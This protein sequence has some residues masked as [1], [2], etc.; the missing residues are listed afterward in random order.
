VS[1]LSSLKEHF[2]V[3]IDDQ[4]AGSFSEGQYI[5]VPV[6]PGPHTFSYARASQVSFNEKKHTLDVAPGQSVYFEVAE[7]QQGMVTVM[8]PHQVPPEQGQPAL[9]GLQA[10]GRD[11]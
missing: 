5:S 3:A 4:S 2:G 11:D 8:Y 1:F 10:P 6:Q 9:A 7:E